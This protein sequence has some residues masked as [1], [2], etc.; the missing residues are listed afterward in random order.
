[1]RKRPS[2]RQGE[3]PQKEPNLPTR[4]TWTS[5][6]RTERQYTSGVQAPSV[7]YF[8]AAAIG[9]HTV[10]DGPWRPRSTTGPGM[11]PKSE[12]RGRRQHPTRSHDPKVLLCTIL[13]S[14][15]KPPWL[16]GEP[17][18]VSSSCVT[19]KWIEGQN[20]MS[21]LHICIFCC[22]HW[23]AFEAGLVPIS[24]DNFKC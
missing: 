6:P 3:R 2:A 22:L 11:V 9:M 14:P 24:K 12:Q 15:G 4:C 23:L 19:I 21:V 20:F 7:W 1:M 18:L 13:G 8:D 17:E 16:E 5:A 10:V